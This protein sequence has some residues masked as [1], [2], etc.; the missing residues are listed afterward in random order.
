MI[1]MQ[2]LLF[3]WVQAHWALSFTKARDILIPSAK[4]ITKNNT[5]SKFIGV[6][7]DEDSEYIKKVIEDVKLHGIQLHGNES[8]SFCQLF[9]IR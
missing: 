4:M 8:N 7:V 5:N 3:L 1:M 9:D 6:F 2:N